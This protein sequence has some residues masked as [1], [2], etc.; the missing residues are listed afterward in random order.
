MSKKR[1]GPF[2]FPLSSPCDEEDKELFRLDYSN[3]HTK[4]LFFIFSHP[5]AI[6]YIVITNCFAKDVSIMVENN[7][8]F[9]G[10]LND[11]ET[12]ILF[13]CEASITK[14]LDEEKLSKPIT[15]LNQRVEKNDKYISLYI[16]NFI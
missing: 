13:T 16:N 4:E 5:Y 14:Y 12:L 2:K 6:S 1:N 8:V 11:K 9:E 7:V 3:E 15:K 10:G